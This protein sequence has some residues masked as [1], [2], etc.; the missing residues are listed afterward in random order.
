MAALIFA[1]R[2]PTIR[3]YGGDL[4]SPHMEK[5]SDLVQNCRLRS[6]PTLQDQLG[7]HFETTFGVYWCCYL[8]YRLLN[9]IC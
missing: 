2:G 6:Y 8:M 1:S 7:G 4:P 5:F 3:S 9:S